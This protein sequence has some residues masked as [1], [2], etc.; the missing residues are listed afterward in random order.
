MPHDED[1]HSS[2]GEA[3]FASI[4]MDGGAEFAQMR[5]EDL[6]DFDDSLIPEALGILGDSSHPN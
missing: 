4:G 1:V 5:A 3:E 6:P 2:E